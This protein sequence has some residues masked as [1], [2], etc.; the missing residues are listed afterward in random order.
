MGGH[1]PRIWALFTE[2]VC[3]NERIG[4][5]RGHVL[6]MPPRSANDT[7]TR[8]IIMTRSNCCS[9]SQEHFTG[10]SKKLM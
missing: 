6:G 9:E 10:K 3:E 4:T 5:I 7:V 2:N 8:V 1:G